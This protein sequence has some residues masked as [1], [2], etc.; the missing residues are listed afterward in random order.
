MMSAL[1]A[2]GDR[3]EAKNDDDGGDALLQE[4]VDSTKLFLSA[5][6]KISSF[7]LFAIPGGEITQENNEG[8]KGTKRNLVRCLFVDSVS[9]DGWEN[10]REGEL[11]E[12]WCIENCRQLWRRHTHFLCLSW[13]CLSIGDDFEFVSRFTPKMKE[14]REKLTTDTRCEFLRVQNRDKV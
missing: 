3:N 5:K 2:R 14:K 11:M 8:V 7:S 1:S 9:M 13:W 10:W 12:T 6:K 4:C